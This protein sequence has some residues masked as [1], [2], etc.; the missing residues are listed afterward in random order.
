MTDQETTRDSDK[1]EEKTESEQ[2]D[3]KPVSPPP[4]H[5]LHRCLSSGTVRETVKDY[6]SDA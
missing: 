3:Q 6:P 1:T 4:P 2:Q 5:R